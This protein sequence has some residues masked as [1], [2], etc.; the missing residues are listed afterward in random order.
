MNNGGKRKNEGDFDGRYKHLLGT[1]E[2]DYRK[3]RFSGA[4]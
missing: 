4:V 1:L 3:R 2:N